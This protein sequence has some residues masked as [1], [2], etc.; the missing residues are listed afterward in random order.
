MKFGQYE[1]RELIAVGGM[2]EVWAAHAEGREG[3]VKPVA[4]K[5]ILESF[6]GD[7]ELERAREQVA[8]GAAG[9][10]AQAGAS[11]QS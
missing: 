7:P 1:L 9:V 8:P 5:F 10:A 2:A 3:F 6:S 4:L 11:S